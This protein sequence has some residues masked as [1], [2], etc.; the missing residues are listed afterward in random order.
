MQTKSID[1]QTDKRD[2]ASPPDSD[3]AWDKSPQDPSA[4]SA[5][6]RDYPF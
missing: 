4:S 3:A 2:A 5:A 6:A 1:D